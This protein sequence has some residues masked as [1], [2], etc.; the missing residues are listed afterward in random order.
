MTSLESDKPKDPITSVLIVGPISPFRSSIATHLTALM[1][2]LESL[3]NVVVSVISFKTLYPSWLFPGERDSNPESYLSSSSIIDYTLSSINPL[4]WIKT[5]RKV[6]DAEP[7]IV[8]IPLW[9]FFPAVCLGWI[10]AK[11]RNHRLSIITIV[12]NVTDHEQSRLK[13]ILL[14][15]QASA[16]D[17]YVFHSKAAFETLSKSFSDKPSV[18]HP[19]PIG[20]GY[21]IRID[22][23]LIGLDRDFQEDAPGKKLLF[24]GLVRPYKGLDMAL[25]ALTL[26][27]D[28]SVTLTVAGE[29]WTKPEAIE[30]QITRL[31]LEHRVSLIP[32]YIEEKQAEEL[33]HGCDLVL[34]PYREISS[35]GVLPL[36]YA[37]GKPVIAS[38]LPGLAE[39]IEHGSTGWIVPEYKPASFA[40]TI[41]EG[42]L[43]ANQAQV[44]SAIRQKALS[45]SWNTYANR[46]LTLDTD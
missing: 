19:L 35:S 45:M 27:S 31:N 39:Q 43:K 44:K 36:A 12:H 30:A 20:R 7:D 3:E 23:T 28:E 4:S 11:C 14:A 17:A 13:S 10:A 37:F 2:Q 26:I 46:L 24:F 6:R 8:I 15:Y 21:P 32:E 40:K 41:E 38:N 9:S 34:L 1:E 25:E 5:A 18:V 22:E 33:F 16:S 42:L 29:F